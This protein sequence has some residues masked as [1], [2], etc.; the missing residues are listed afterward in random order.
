[1]TQQPKGTK[2]PTT[3]FGKENSQP[4][5]NVDT[6]TEQVENEMKGYLTATDVEEHCFKDI[7]TN[8]KETTGKL[9]KQLT[10]LVESTF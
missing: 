10:V 8:Q 7:T 1:M 3:Y 9:P 5:R 2:P 4:G 6:H